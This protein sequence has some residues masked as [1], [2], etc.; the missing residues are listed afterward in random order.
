MNLGETYLDHYERFLG[1]HDDYGKFEHDGVNIQILGYSKTMQDAHILASLGL[2]H[3]QDVLGDVVEIIIPVSELDETVWTAV[4][5]SLDFLLK[6]RQPIQEISYLRYLHRTVPEFYEKYGKSALALASPYPFPDEFATF[7]L[8]PSGCNG[9][10]LMGF[11]L[12]DAEAEF[13]E[14]EG[15]DALATRLEEQKV[16]VIELSRPSVV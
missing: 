9:K 5:S 8:R 4:L 10:V 6:V 1:E 13:I 11:L 2:T 3:F 16:D 7:P 15:F 12:S 14:R